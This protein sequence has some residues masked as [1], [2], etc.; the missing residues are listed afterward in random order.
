MR[1]RRGGSDG[2]GLRGRRREKR[3]F[4]VSIEKKV[5]SENYTTF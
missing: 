2:R 1:K 4:A 3:W 5:L